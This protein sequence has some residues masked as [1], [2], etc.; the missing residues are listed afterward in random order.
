MKLVGSSPMRTVYFTLAAV[1][2]VMALLIRAL[3]SHVPVALFALLLAAVFLVL[4]LR[5]TARLRRP[6]PVHM[7]E[8]QEE[9]LRRLVDVGQYGT[10]VGQ[11]RLWFRDATQ[12]EAV[13][14]VD[15]LAHRR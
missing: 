3:T 15:G 13:A 10:A 11:V 4:G 14:I 12:E 8:E 9:E 7:N 2:C 1:A 5:K 6:Q